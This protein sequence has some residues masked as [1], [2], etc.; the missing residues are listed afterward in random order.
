MKDR[1]YLRKLSR[2]FIG[3]VGVENRSTKPMLTGD[4][5]L[6][7]IYGFW[8]MFNAARFHFSRITMNSLQVSVMTCEPY[9]VAKNE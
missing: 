4:K 7:I 5:N 9:E 1:I 6:G 2:I 8:I 3:I